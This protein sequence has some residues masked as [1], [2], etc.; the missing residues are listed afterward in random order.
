MR[1]RRLKRLTPIDSAKIKDQ[2]T[3]SGLVLGSRCPI[4]VLLILAVVLST[5]FTANTNAQEISRPNDSATPDAHNVQ[6]RQLARSRYV[7]RQ[8]AT[9]EMWRGRTLS[10][11][12]VQDA[13]HNPDP[14]IA[15]RAEWILKQW[16][17]GA[18]PGVGNLSGGLLLD[19]GNPSALAAVLEQGAFNAVLVAVEESAGT[20][21]YDQIKSRVAQ[22]L[23]Q[24]FPFYSDHALAN[25]T[26]ADLLRLMDAVAIDRN[27]AAATRDLSIFLG[28]ERDDTNRIPSA[29]AVW[30]QTERDIYSAQLAMLDGDAQRSV[31]AARRAGDPV[32]LRITQMLVDQWD[33]IATEAMS[34]A[35]NAA[36]DEERV[37]SLAW[38]FAAAYRTGNDALVK[39]VAG[40]LS[41]AQAGE[42][43]DV[44]NLRWRS[45]AIHGD[46]DTAI[47]VLAVSD[48]AAA[49]KVACAASR[50]DRAAQL[51]GF[52]L[53]SI[54]R[55]LDQWISDAYVEQA[56][57][58]AGEIAPAMERLYSLA[59]LLI[60]VGDSEN[61]IRIYRRLT[62]RQI[63]VSPYGTSL[64]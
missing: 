63:I 20:I 42:S 8:R 1:D 58:P 43:E 18:L 6:P 44:T 61:A 19:R 28:I 16:R 38:A 51:C 3:S 52:E 49:A 17:S 5:V 48:P 25:G 26:Q 54:D 27:V 36:T 7:D 13:A 15:E 35:E 21:E 29:A 56:E 11:Q 14:E 46:V 33:A 23:T 37:E 32:L 55:D 64:R 4:A 39:E 62:P 10:R 41:V 40:Q 34:G 24:R 57:Y 50:F 9:L 31:E 22:Q 53:E 45:L 30:S 59:R 60:N 2:P 12:A 47:N